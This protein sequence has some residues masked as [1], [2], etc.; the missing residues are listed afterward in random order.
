M[1]QIQYVCV[2]S[3]GNVIITKEAFDEVVK[4]SY[5]NGYEDGLK[6]S[7]IEVDKLKE[8]SLEKKAN[9]KMWGGWKGNHDQRIENATCSN[10]GYKHPTVKVSLSLLNKYCPNCQCTMVNVD[11]GN[12]RFEVINH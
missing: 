1:K 11:Y 8:S 5:N 4:N 2:D 7:S 10:C 9:W 12:G 3:N 6:Q